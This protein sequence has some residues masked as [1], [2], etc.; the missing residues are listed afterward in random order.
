MLFCPQKRS[1]LVGS[2]TMDLILHPIKATSLF[3]RPT[4]FSAKPYPITKDRRNS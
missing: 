2:G 3:P 1:P 4:Y